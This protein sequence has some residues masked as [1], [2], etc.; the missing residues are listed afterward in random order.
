METNNSDSSNINSRPQPD[1]S[2]ETNSSKKRKRSKDIPSHTRILAAC[3]ACR[4]SK[5]RCDSARP[6]CA[7]CAERGLSCR[8]PDKDPFSIFETWG[9]NILGAVE[10]QGRLLAALAEGGR[11]GLH[12]Q[13][14]DQ[15]ARLLDMDGENLETM[16]R[17]DTPWTPIT[18]SD[19]I[20]SWSVFPQERPVSTFPATEFAEKPKPSDFEV[21]NPSPERMFELRD[22]YMSKIQGKNPIVDADQLDAHIAYVLE[23]GFGWTATSCLVLLVFA[24]AA[25]WGN[26]PDDERR[27]VETHEQL[28]IY[29]RHRVT[30]AVPDHR[31]R[32]SLMYIAMAQ[33][34]MSTAYLDDSLLGVNGVYDVGSVQSEAFRWENATAKARRDEVRHELN[35]LPPC[36][37]QESSFPYALPTFPTIESFGQSRVDARHDAS[38]VHSTTLSYYYYLAE[39][40]LRRLLNRTRSAA[41]VLSPT[42]DSLTAARLAETMQKLEGQLQQWL[43]CLPLA[44][45]F[46]IPPDSHPSPEEPELVKLMR[47]RYAEVRE[48]LC[49]AYLYMCLHGGMRLTRSQAETFGAQAS[50][51]LRLSVYRIQT[52]NPFFRHPGSW[53]A[54]R[55]R[56]NHALCLM[57]AYR[58]KQAG[59]ESAA[60]VL[61]PPMWR[62]CVDTVQERLE[63]WADQGGGIR[64]LAVLLDWLKKL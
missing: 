40:S 63:T 41:T 28:D 29:P 11:N 14:P 7:K 13:R 26:Y 19:M 39:I 46:H 10:E 5:T 1:N 33:K 60:H 62:E 53:G 35:G 32:E 2:M 49:R 27:H 8:Y 64:E 52:E 45:R 48:L 3:D 4:V 17:K 12:Q 16:S 31:M 6:T 23:N 58:G 36:T 47:E 18:G 38:T 57:A 30:M 54:C 24:L 20:L 25:A 42:I 51:G 50:L 56:F 55:V 37:L 61:V 43:D 59:V 34:R 22:I 21:S 15:L 44:L 9:K